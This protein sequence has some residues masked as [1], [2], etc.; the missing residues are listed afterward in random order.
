MHW[1]LFYAIFNFSFL[2]CKTLRRTTTT[3][4][5][6]DASSVSKPNWTELQLRFGISIVWKICEKIIARTWQVAFTIIFLFFTSTCHWLHDMAASK[7]CLP[8]KSRRMPRQRSNQ[9]LVKRNNWILS[10][11]RSM[12]FSIPTF[13]IIFT[14][15]IFLYWMQINL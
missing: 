14:L 5:T 15:L 11:Y 2:L 9:K 13:S 1:H 6:T 10:V 7:F 12:S 4:T 3:S 8:R